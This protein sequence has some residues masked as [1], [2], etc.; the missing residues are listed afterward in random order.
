MVCSHKLSDFPESRQMSVRA[1]DRSS[2]DNIFTTPD[3]LLYYERELK[4]VFYYRG[5]RK[6]PR[7]H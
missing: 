2:K 6:I 4:I 5:R 3:L 1:N 7:V